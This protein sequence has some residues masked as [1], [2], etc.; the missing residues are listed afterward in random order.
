MSH[1]P[2]RLTRP[3]V[4]GRWVLALWVLATLGICPPAHA[5]VTAVAEPANAALERAE[6][7]TLQ[8]RKGC[9]GATSYASDS[10]LYPAYASTFCIKRP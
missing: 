8:T 6:P 9:T 7:M 3:P 5:G 4:T 2:V 1:P 10:H